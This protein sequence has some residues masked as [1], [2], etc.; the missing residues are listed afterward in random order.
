MKEIFI[1][2]IRINRVRHLRDI[3]IEL[4]ATS[5][6]HLI[7]TGKNGSGKTSL[8]LEVKKVFENIVRRPFSE[9]LNVEI[10]FNTTD[11]IKVGYHSGE[12]ILA[13]FA[14]NRASASSLPSGIKKVD[15]KKVY[16]IV[17]K[18]SQQF[19]QYIVNMKAER[20]FA[21]DDNDTETVKRID[22]WFEK[23]QEC[24]REIFEDDS[25]ELIFDRKNFNFVI[26]QAEREPFDFNT[27]SDGYSAI[28]D[29]VTELILRMEKTINRGY[30]V[31]GIVLIDE[32]ETHLHV[33][34]QKKILPFLTSFF[35][36]IQFIVTTHS[37]FILNS[38][39]NAVIYDLENKISVEDLSGYAYDGLVESYF[40]VDKYSEAIKNKIE[41]YAELVEKQ[42]KNE[43]E[44]EQM[45]DL[46]NYLKQTPSEFAPELY[47][48]FAEIEL[49]R[50]EESI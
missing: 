14:A 13:M 47:S 25:T 9:N 17:D 50:K 10:E 5:K 46:R 35:P 12:F 49:S 3:T 1:K 37:P 44:Y 41:T 43:T 23:F 36:G 40:N 45:I 7:I 31:Q 42:D 30:D 38:I 48:R 26:K 11:A 19:I 29:I 28:L 33:E 21:R 34:L 2:Q 27:L 20:S 32:I 18:A 22:E 6:K 39:E 24:L 16:N 4:D 15:I 8:L